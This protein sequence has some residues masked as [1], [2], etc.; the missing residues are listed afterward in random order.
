MKT[1][2]HVAFVTAC[3]I[4]CTHALPKTFNKM[5]EN[6]L[7]YFWTIPDIAKIP[8]PE[9]ANTTSTTKIINGHVVT[10]NET[11]YTSSDEN[12]GTAFR[13]RIIDVKPENDTI[14]TLGGDNAEPTTVTAEATESNETLED[15]NEI[16]KN[17]DV[18]TA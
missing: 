10:I 17:P 1:F 9:G 14:P 6:L 8:I 2:V 3:L 11:T 15:M 5:R 7:N 12:G 4:A 16:P 18:L 13:I